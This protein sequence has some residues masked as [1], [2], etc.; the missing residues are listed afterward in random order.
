MIE[1][2]SLQT[3]KKVIAGIEVMLIIKKGQTPQGEKFVQYH[4]RSGL[5]I[6]N[7]VPLGIFHS[8]FISHYFCIRTNNSKLE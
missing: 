7:S 4:N 8:F 3:A 6:F 1:L 2:N 5:I